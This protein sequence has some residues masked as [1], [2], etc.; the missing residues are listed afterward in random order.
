MKE[1]NNLIVKFILYFFM[2]NMFFKLR[3]SITLIV[4][5]LLLS[6]V[7]S[8]IIDYHIPKYIEIDNPYDPKIKEKIKNIEFI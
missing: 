8:L 3:K 5:A 2:L 1:I 7:G 6:F 4:L